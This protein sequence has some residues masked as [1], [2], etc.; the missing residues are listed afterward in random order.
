MTAI[1]TAIPTSPG[2]SPAEGEV[3]RME[4]GIRLVGWGVPGPEREKVTQP[5]R[6]TPGANRLGMSHFSKTA[7]AMG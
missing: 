6:M 1:S 3:P 4:A 7:R 5:P 2:T